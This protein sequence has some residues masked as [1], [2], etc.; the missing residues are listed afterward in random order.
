M[1]YIYIVGPL[2]STISP[3]SHHYYLRFLR[4]MGWVLSSDV[5]A[6]HWELSHILLLVPVAISKGHSSCSRGSKWWVSGKYGAGL[7]RLERM[8][9]IEWEALP[10]GVYRLGTLIF[11]Q[12]YRHMYT[13][14]AVA[15]KRDGNR[16]KSHCP[17]PKMG[18]YRNS[19]HD[20]CLLLL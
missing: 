20:T 12:G 15:L 8:E 9:R 17:C 16:M 10:R 14:N 19:F 11:L 2:R 3:S 13:K 5:Y 1:R 18:I 7:G 4:R 6:P